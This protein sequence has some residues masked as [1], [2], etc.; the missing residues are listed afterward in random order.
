M[1][2][3]S[4]WHWLI[5]LLILLFMIGLPAL[6]VAKEDTELLTS[7]REFLLWITAYIGVPMII[8]LVGGLLG[9]DGIS[10]LIGLVFVFA[11][12]YPL[13]QRYV[14]RARDAGMGKN[15]AYLSI[16]PVVAFLTTI[17]LLVKPSRTTAST[18][19]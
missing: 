19:P 7:R 4:I 5:V 3:F 15:I 2:T 8:G 17:I 14:R 11:V 9:D 18:S 16:I 1:G 12:I 6:A 10:Q 13:Y